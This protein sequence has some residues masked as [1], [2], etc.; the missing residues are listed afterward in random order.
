M[1]PQKTVILVSFFLIWASF[2]LFSQNQNN[3]WRFGLNGA[4]DFNT[5]PPTSPAGCALQTPEGSASIA[6]RLT[7]ELLFYTDGITVWNA[8][9]QPMPNGTGLLGGT[10]LLLSSTSAAVII[11]KPFSPD[12]YYIATIDEQSSGNGV[13]YSVVDMSLNGGLGDILPAQKNVLLF[14]TT[15]EKLHVV[16]TADGC[17]YWL[18]TH[19]SPGNTFA[20]FKI[21][22][23]GIETPPVL[24]SV[25]GAQGNGAGHFKINRQ[26]NKLAMGNLFD[27]TVELFDFNNATG[28]VSNPLIW[29]YNFPNA[30][31]YGVEFSPDGSKLYVS[32]IERIIQYDIS[33]TG[34][35]AIEASAFNISQ[36]AG[37]GYQPASLQ[38]GPDNKIYIAAA[39]LDA[40][41]FPNQSGA[42]CG[43]Q[44]NIIAALNGTTGYGL[45]QWIYFSDFSTSGI[46]VSNDTCQNK[47][48]SFSVATS[49][50]VTSIEWDFGDPASG[51]G[52]TANAL[53]PIHLFSDTGAYTVRAIVNAACGLDTITQEILIV[54]CNC[55]VYIPNAF[56]PNGDDINDAFGLVAFCNLEQMELS[57]YNR[58]GELVYQTSNPAEKWDGRYNGDICPVDVYVYVINYKQPNETAKT[59]HGDVTLVR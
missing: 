36:N 58:W 7:G 50:D 6:D 20:A 42:S 59:V 52:N 17:G 19:D 3:Q 21:T 30:L 16:P 47:N 48:I 54:N 9:N 45:P 18:L 5:T 13:R 38:L 40:I 10:S 24:S 4:V 49:A 29:D 31:I 43:F 44:R 53:E 15:S 25:G 56:S 11:P 26:L 55:N 23:N 46:I 14:N 28:V 34:A 37:V 2:S 35:A 57:V 51:T 22:Q 32:N 41:Q 1:L 39:S 27:S 12:I 8:N 33:Q